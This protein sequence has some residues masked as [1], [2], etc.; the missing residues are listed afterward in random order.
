[1]LIGSYPL[2]A[3]LSIRA[4]MGVMSTVM[5]RF[6]CGPIIHHHRIPGCWIRG[7]LR[8]IAARKGPC[9]PKVLPAF[10]LFF[11]KR[12]QLFGKL[13]PR[14]RQGTNPM[15]SS[16]HTGIRLSVCRDRTKMSRHSDS[17]PAEIR[18]FYRRRRKYTIRDAYDFLRIHKHKSNG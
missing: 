8:L 18:L 16:S 10:D 13:V 7:T 6:I 4:S 3:E 15:P 11:G 14:G 1:M 9:I 2:A 17:Q 12:W 5:Q